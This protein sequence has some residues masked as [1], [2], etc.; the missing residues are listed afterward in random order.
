MFEN[1]NSLFR[2]KLLCSDTVDLLEEEH[3]GIS[4][5][6]QYPSV[7][8]GIFLH[9]TRIRIGYCDL[10]IGMNEE[11]YYAGNVG[12]RI[13]E[14]YRGHGYAYDACLLL[15]EAARSRYHM[16]ELLITCSPDNIA[17]R[18]TLEKLGGILK[19]TADVPRSHWLYARGERVKNIY[20][21]KL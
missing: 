10:R 3:R 18:K 4:I 9:G 21:Y 1:I 15:F 20:L 6:T 8:F 12:Y 17:S 7:D 5:M 14:Q 13:Q 2:P 11:L 16:K 19:E